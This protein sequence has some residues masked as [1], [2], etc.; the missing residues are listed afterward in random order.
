MSVEKGTMVPTKLLL[1][2]IYVYEP[3][4]PHNKYLPRFQKSTTM[5]AYRRLFIIA[6]VVLLSWSRVADAGRKERDRGDRSKISV[7]EKKT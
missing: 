7:S 2:A 1:L 5:N 6:F 4:P 3:L